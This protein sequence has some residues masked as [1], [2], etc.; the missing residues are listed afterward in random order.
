MRTNGDIIR[1]SEDKV[2][3]ATFAGWFDCSTEICP[4]AVSME[5]KADPDDRA[6]CKAMWLEWLSSRPAAL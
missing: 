2:L 5:C 4:I 6:A 3:A 1:D